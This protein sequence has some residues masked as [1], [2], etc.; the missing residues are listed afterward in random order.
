M[1]SLTLEDWRTMRPV[2][3]KCFE[4]HDGL[5]HHARIEWDLAE[6]EAEHEGKSKGGKK[7][8]TK[9]KERRTRLQS[10]SQ[11]V[12]EPQP[13]SK[14][15]TKCVVSALDEGLEEEWLRRTTSRERNSRPTGSDISSQIVATV[16]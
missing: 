2:I 5:W 15:I 10:Q 9:L 16:S 4:V 6:D 14:A 1:T 13:E 7:A 11:L 12:P 8:Q 3:E